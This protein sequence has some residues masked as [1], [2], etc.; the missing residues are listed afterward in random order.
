[1]STRSNAGTLSTPLW[2]E[3]VV[4]DNLLPNT[5]WQLT[6]KLVPDLDKTSAMKA[7]GTETQAQIDIQ[8]F[9]VNNNQPTFYSH[10]TRELYSGAIVV[11]GGNL[12][13]K[14]TY[15]LRV[16][17]LVPNVS[18]KCQLP[19]GH[20]SPSVSGP[21]TAF[22]AGIS[23]PGG[24][25]FAPDGGWSK[26]ESLAFWIDD[27]RE[28]RCPGAK[29]V[30]GLRKSIN[31]NENF[32]WTCATERL[33]EFA[34]RKITFGALL[35][36]K[37]TTTAA[38]PRLFI[39]DSST[40]SFSEWAKVGALSDPT[41]GNYQLLT[42][43]HPVHKQTTAL[44]LG[45]EFHGAK[46]DITYL[47]TPTLKFGGLMLA[48]DLGQNRSEFLRADTHWN[49]PSLVPF[50]STSPAQPLP[51][52]TGQDNPGL[53]GWSNLD[54]EALSLCQCHSSV[55][56]VNCKIEL[57]TETPGLRFFVAALDE[58][59]VQLVFGP[60]QTTQVKNQMIVGGPAMLPLRTG[61]PWAGS[62]PGCFSMFCDRPN[63]AIANVTF[64]FDDVLC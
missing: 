56:K 11:F 48:A 2:A 34:G 16:L 55:S 41:Y 1:M 59:R 46:G 3:R 38:S 43:S 23:Q 53:F 22:A 58:A 52:T 61:E 36:L 35:R 49:P 31:D 30:I 5:N 19:F 28:N 12:S 50:A 27:F 15:A 40:S 32:L 21:I 18:F 10:N 57:T 51:N 9:D 54:L 29:R 25:A 39:S 6:S 44:A 60:Q 45:V 20:L 63:A 47:A 42:V 37:R 26:T 33:L 24:T 17:G 13:P 7:D 4:G 8:S 64:D 14:P 62:P